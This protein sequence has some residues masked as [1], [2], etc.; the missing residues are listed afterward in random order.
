VAATSE[1]DKR[2]LTFPQMAISLDKSSWRERIMN[3]SL[4]SS[5]YV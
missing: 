1:E 4:E 3:A 5:N 2:E